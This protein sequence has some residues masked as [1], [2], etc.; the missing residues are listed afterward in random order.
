MFDKYNELFELYLKVTKS[1]YDIRKPY[2]NLDD[3]CTT[4]ERFKWRL[5]GMLEL[6]ES[7]GEITSEKEE[8][9]FERVL[10]EFSTI[11]LFNA[12]MEEGEIRVYSK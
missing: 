3:C 12:Y 2:D 5:A 4:C 11:K 7:T 8:Q 9:E 10:D 1:K 6:L